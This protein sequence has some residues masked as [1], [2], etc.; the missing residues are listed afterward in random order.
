MLFQGKTRFL[1]EAS[2]TGPD[3]TVKLLN[4]KTTQCSGDILLEVTVSGNNVMLQRLVASE[5]L[6]VVI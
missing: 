5:L 4:S 2:K 6:V 1:V 3:K